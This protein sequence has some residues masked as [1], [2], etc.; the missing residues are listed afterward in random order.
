[1][2]EHGILV[3]PNSVEKLAQAFIDFMQMD[4]QQINDNNKKALNYIQHNF[5]LENI[6]NQWLEMYA[7]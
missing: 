3:Q 1:M 6:V 2:G 5:D 7:A 4:T